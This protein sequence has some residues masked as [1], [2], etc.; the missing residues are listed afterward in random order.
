MPEKPAQLV[1][2]Q[3][4]T[5]RE[6]HRGCEHP[7]ALLELQRGIGV[8]ERAD[9]VRDDPDQPEELLERSL[10]LLG[11]RGGQRPGDP[12]ALRRVVERDVLGARPVLV[13]VSEVLRRSAVRERKQPRGE[14]AQ[15]MSGRHLPA[16]VQRL[17][18]LLRRLQR[19]QPALDERRWN[20]ELEGRASGHLC[21]A[22]PQLRRAR[23]VGLDEP[24]VLPVPREDSHRERCVA[25]E[26]LPG[27][28]EDDG[29]RRWVGHF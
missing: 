27:N 6:E 16:H 13:D 5:S 24:G 20:P 17:P 22:D 10:D 8:R 11:Q 9:L 2:G 18:E 29:R 1:N 14:R 15:A 23:R 26:I 12:L 25:E 21:R 19:H 3:V 4:R 7:A 28:R